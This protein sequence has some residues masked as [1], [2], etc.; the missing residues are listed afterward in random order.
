M[1][2]D[3]TSNYTGL[4]IYILDGSFATNFIFTAF[5]LLFT[6]PIQVQVVTICHRLHLY[7]RFNVV[8][9]KIYCTLQ[10]AYGLYRLAR[11]CHQLHTPERQLKKTATRP[12]QQPTQTLP[13]LD[14]YIPALMTRLI[15]IRYTEPSPLLTPLTPQRILASQ[16]DRAVEDRSLDSETPIC[17]V[18]PV[19]GTTPTENLQLRDRNQL[20]DIADILGTTAFKGY[21]NPP[22]QTLDGI[23]VQQPKWFFPLAKEAK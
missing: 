22:I 15:L 2:P 1:A 18:Q 12:H 7:K 9:K 4:A 17:Q 23:L 20:E 14:E 5:L 10:A 21:V 3:C 19:L 11:E 8:F 16:Q 6:I 13:P